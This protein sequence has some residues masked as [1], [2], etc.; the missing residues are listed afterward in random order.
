MQRFFFKSL[1]R[2]LQPSQHRLRDD[3]L[4]RFSQDSCKRA[5]STV[6]IMIIIIR[7]KRK[8]KYC[9]ELNCIVLFMLRKV[10]CIHV[11]IT[12]ILLL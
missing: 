12:S 10:L 6:I 1:G 4:L 11:I 9:K 3:C 2:D 7:R 8:K 5:P